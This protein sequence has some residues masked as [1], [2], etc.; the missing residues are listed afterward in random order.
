MNKYPFSIRAL[1]WLTV[2]LVALQILLGFF[3][4]DWPPLFYGHILIGSIVLLVG[5]IRLLYRKGHLPPSRPY[6]LSPFQWKLAKFGHFILYIGLILTPISGALAALYEGVFE[7]AH[8]TLVFLFI[9]LIIGHVLMIVKHL[10][11]DKV[12]LIERMG[13]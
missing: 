7:E 10:V 12:N 9:G 8:E 3:M 2:V 13:L 1:H 5:V 11:L 4:E 6:G